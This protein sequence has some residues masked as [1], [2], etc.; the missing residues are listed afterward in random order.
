MTTSTLSLMEL[1]RA[2]ATR[3]DLVDVPELLVVAV[4]GA[5]SP[6]GPA[7]AEAIQ[8]LYPVSYGAHFLLKKRTG[9]AP[10]V[11]PLEALWWVDDQ[12]AQDTFTLVATGQASV[13]D[14]DRALW[15]WRA[16]I[17]QPEPVD[18]ALLAEAVEGARVKAPAIDRLYIERWHE[19]LAAQ[20]LHVGPYAAEAPTIVRLHDAIA[21]LG[22]QARGRHHEIYLGD[23]RR[24]A[25]EKLR[26]IIRHPV[27]L[28]GG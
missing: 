17:V 27:Q 7:F 21:G 3:V 8:T 25:P 9:T 28:I 10:R 18:E 11:M 5:G 14:V 15:R 12:A 23:P 26:T 20:V 24:S 22:Y 6:E 19:G 4:D 1:Y 13:D 2:R 16:L